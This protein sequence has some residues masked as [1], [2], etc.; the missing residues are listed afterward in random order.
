MAYLWRW[1]IELYGR[2]GLGLGGVAPLSHRELR[3][4]AENTGERPTRREVEALMRIDAALRG[5]KVVGAE[6]REA[7]KPSQSAAWPKRGERRSA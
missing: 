4:W 7:P 3:A 1:A 2:S 6:K 5:A